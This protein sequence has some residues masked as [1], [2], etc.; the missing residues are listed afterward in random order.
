MVGSV[1]DTTMNSSTQEITLTQEVDQLPHCG[2]YNVNLVYRLVYYQSSYRISYYCHLKIIIE[3]LVTFQWMSELSL[4]N[5]MLLYPRW[6]NMSGRSGT[7]R[8]ICVKVEGDVETMEMI[9]LSQIELMN[10]REEPQMVFFDRFTK[11]P[12]ATFAR[13]TVLYHSKWDYYQLWMDTVIN[14]SIQNSSIMGWDQS[15]DSS[16]FGRWSSLP[17][18]ILSCIMQ[19]E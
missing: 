3:G 4:S 17:L 19:N 2:Q 9:D 10:S 15:I 1:N 13:T 16:H 12:T 8:N 11:R 7:A 5:T 6:V 18:H 14:Y